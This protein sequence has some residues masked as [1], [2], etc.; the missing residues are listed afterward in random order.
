[1]LSDRLRPSP[2]RPAVWTLVWWLGAVCCL[3]QSEGVIPEALQ[4]MTPER[5]TSPASRMAGMEN[6]GDCVGMPTARLRE[7][8]RLR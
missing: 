8:Y 6:A 3:G 7:P 4:P 5:R 1:M 2:I